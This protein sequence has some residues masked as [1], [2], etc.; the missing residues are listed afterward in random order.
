MFGRMIKN[1]C[2]G[3]AIVAVMGILS[4]THSLI[5]MQAEAHGNPALPASVSQKVGGNNIGGDMEG[6][7]VR[8]GLAGSGLFRIGTTAGTT[9][10]A[11]DSKIPSLKMAKDTNTATTHP[12]T[13]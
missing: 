3:Y 6:K 10:S 4:A 2:Q 8:F 5:E 7:E 11:L 1:R 13:T 9:D 12:R